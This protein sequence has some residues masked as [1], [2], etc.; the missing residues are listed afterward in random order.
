MSAKK[1]NSASNWSNVSMIQKEYKSKYWIHYQQKKRPRQLNQKITYNYFI[2]MPNNLQK[3]L[4]LWV[5]SKNKNKMAAC[6]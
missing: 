4:S 5:I 2:W 3:L 1:D 6:L